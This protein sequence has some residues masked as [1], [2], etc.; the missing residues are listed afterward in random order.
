MSVLMSAMLVS[1][2]IGAAFGFI[3]GFVLG[4][5]F[6]PKQN[7]SMGYMAAEM[8]CINIPDVAADDVWRDDLDDPEG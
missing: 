3:V 4:A 7:N 2:A 1:T 5:E 8:K 6:E